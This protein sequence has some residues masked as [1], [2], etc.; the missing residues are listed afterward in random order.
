MM[1]QWTA[2]SR[3]ADCNLFLATVGLRFVPFP[4]SSISFDVD[5]FKVFTNLKVFPL[6]CKGIAGYRRDYLVWSYMHHYA[7]I[8]FAA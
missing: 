5:V 2:L 7:A 8:Q 6:G 4:L 1:H 3:V